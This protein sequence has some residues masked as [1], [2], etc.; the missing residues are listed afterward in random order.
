MKLRTVLLCGAACAFSAGAV[1]AQAETARSGARG[2]KRAKS[3]RA[4]ANQVSEVI[5]TATKRNTRLEKTPIAITAFSQENLDRAGIKDVTDMAQF[6][7]SLAY[8]EHADQGSINLTLRGIGNDSAFT[9]VAD[10]E[11]ALYV[12]GIYSPRAQGA[13]CSCTTCRASKWIAARRA[14]CSDATRRR[15]PST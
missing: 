1:E 8:S 13:T 3:R 10:P 9:E 14:R 11:V 15:A 12:D 6:V 2:P 7:P 5:V 4:D